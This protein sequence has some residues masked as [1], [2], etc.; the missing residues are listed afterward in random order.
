MIERMKAIS[1]GSRENVKVPSCR[2][3]CKSSTTLQ[4][5]KESAA[6]LQTIDCRKVWGKQ[7]MGTEQGSTHCLVWNSHKYPANT[8]SELKKYMRQSKYGCVRRC[9]PAAY[10]VKAALPFGSSNNELHS[11]RLSIA[12]KREANHQQNST[13]LPSLFGMK[14]TQVPGN[15]TATDLQ[16]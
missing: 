8:A 3:S 6:L 7:P 13:R 1:E 14:F 11:C 5:F 12:E 15:N 2:L 16:Y 4:L 9:L 10:P